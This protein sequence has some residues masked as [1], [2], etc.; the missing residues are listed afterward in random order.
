M[1]VC[2]P[3]TCR[4]MV[5]QLIR[6]ERI[7][8][9]VP[10]AKELRRLADQVVT[11]GKEVRLCLTAAVLLQAALQTMSERASKL[12]CPILPLLSSLFKQLALALLAACCSDLRTKTG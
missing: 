2:M 8:T 11:L 4:T 6:H 10:R 7:Q 1:V 3:C 12:T 9:T 5:S